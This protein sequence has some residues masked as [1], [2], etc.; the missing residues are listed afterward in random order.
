MH[1]PCRVTARSQTATPRLARGAGQ[2]PGD[3]RKSAQKSHDNGIKARDPRPSVHALP[4]RCCNRTTDCVAFRRQTLA[5]QPGNFVPDAQ[6]APQECATWP[7]QVHARGGRMNQ[8]TR[9][10][11]HRTD[12]KTQNQ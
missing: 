4:V 5:D 8:D 6:Q 12:L 7:A 3:K 10:V 1:L 2:C 11:K 9:S